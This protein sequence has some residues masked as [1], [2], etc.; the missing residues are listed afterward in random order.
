M[1][2]KI[3]KGIIISKSP[4]L[5]NDEM[6][7]VLTNESLVKIY[8]KGVRKIESKNRPNVM[9]GALVNFEI[10]ESYS[11]LNSFLLKKATSIRGIPEITKANAQKIEMIIKIIGKIKNFKDDL[12]DIYNL[13]LNDFNS[14]HFFKIQSYFVSKI[15]ESNGEGLSFLN[16]V[17]CSTNQNLFSFDTAQGGMLCKKHGEHATSLE[18]LKSFYFMG[19]SLEK[20]VELTSAEVNQKIFNIIGNLLFW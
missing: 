14:A 8:A 9:L 18:L 3:I 17:I 6:L 13:L 10:F 20:Y 1:K 12:Y 4:Y 16:C 11:S 2:T 15:L 7:N 5:D 19:E